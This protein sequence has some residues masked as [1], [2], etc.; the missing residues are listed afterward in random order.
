LPL[1]SRDAITVPQQLEDVKYI[2]GYTIISEEERNG[3][4][5]QQNTNTPTDN[6]TGHNEP[7]IDPPVN[8]KLPQPDDDSKGTKSKENM[9]KSDWIMSIFTGVIA[10]GTIVSA[11]A[12]VLQWREMKSG[13]A[14]TTAIRLAAQQ[15]AD[16]AE[17]IRLASERN[18]TAA[19][20]FATSAGHINDGISAAVLKLD[21]QAKATQESANAA[22]SAAKT[23]QETLHVSERAY[24][25]PLQPAL[26]PEGKNVS[27]PFANVGHLEADQVQAV[28]HEATIEIAHPDVVSE[29]VPTEVHWKRLTIESIFPG[30]GNTI[31]FPLPAGDSTKIN[32]G[33]QQI[34]LVGFITYKDGFAVEGEQKGFFCFASIYLPY[35]KKLSWNPCDS[36]KYMAELTKLDGYPANEMK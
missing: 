33:L 15:Q 21:A 9:S 27:L 13:S 19:E 17:K 23:A 35:A 31:E 4:D 7:P 36:Q 12:I 2:L 18:A 25:V 14:D 11:V 29:I 16:S 32:T 30:P 1:L 26:S 34:F 22:K 5:E 10:V 6:D 3:M 24:I 20:G 28:V 8:Q